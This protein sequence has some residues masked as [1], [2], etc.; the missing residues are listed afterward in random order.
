MNT[1]AF[2]SLPDLGT[3][4]NTLQNDV[5]RGECGGEDWIRLAQSREKVVGSCEYSSVHA[6]YMKSLKFLSR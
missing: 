2:V 6:C 5:K 1:C 4:A 3:D